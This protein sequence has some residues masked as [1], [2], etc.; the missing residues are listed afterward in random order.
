[1]G[2]FDSARTFQTVSSPASRQPMLRALPTL[3]LLLIVLGAAQLHAAP[4][5][6]GDDVPP[7]EVES[8]IGD[9]KGFAERSVRVVLFLD[10]TSE[11]SVVALR[12]VAALRPLHPKVGFAAITIADAE[13]VEQLESRVSK[14]GVPIGRDDDRSV[15]D[16][17]LLASNHLRVP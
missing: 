10:P 11:E 15:W 9:D 13:D 12:F 5:V 8:W 4:L 7:F 2:L 1:S 17:W 14:L 16:A 3:C 6:V